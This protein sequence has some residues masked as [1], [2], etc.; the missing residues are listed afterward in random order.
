M[1]ATPCGS[2]RRNNKKTFAGG[3]LIS[4]EDEIKKRKDVE[5]HVAYLSVVAENFFEYDGVNY[6]PIVVPL[7]RNPIIRIMS[8][9][10]NETHK[11]KFIEPQLKRV[12]NEVRPD[13]IHVHGTEGLL[14]ICSS[15]TIGVP[16]VFSIQGL[17]APYAEKYFSGIPQHFAL[18]N[19]L[20]YDMI[21][22][23]GIKHNFRSFLYRAEREKKYLQKAQYIFGRTYWD[24]QITGLCN[25]ERKYYIVNEIMRPQFYQKK[26][27]KTAFNERLQI[28]STISGGIY[29]GYETALRA[30][31]LLKDYALF[32]FDWHIVGYD[33]T[34]K[35]VHIAEKLTGLK[36][37]NCNIVFHGRL[38]ADNLS[39]LLV[40]SDINVHVSHIENSTNSVC[41][42]MLVGMPVIASFAGG[43]NSILENGKEGVLL[44]DGDP[45]VL[46]GTVVDYMQN[47]EKAIQYG[48][49]AMVR[50]S[51][52][53]EKQKI[54][55]EVV[56]GYKQIVQDHKSCK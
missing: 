36:S 24:K 56:N 17:I 5:L 11:E 39:D 38:D 19:D 33:N 2:V 26:W 9:A 42:A 14:G 21:R 20:F 34:S 23:S 32:E 47:P 13:I 55:E 8:R 31:K 15:F 53:H 30:A 1:A 46:S 50:A 41:E 37:S 44:Q 22:N 29:K 49:A 18:K 54:V 45:Y 10:R 25:P 28:V 43:T 6:Y 12:I 7:H 4:L 16:L 27:V 40:K 48:N 52:R 51:L 35:W 3:W